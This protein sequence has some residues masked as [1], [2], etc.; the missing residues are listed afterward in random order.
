MAAHLVDGRPKDWMLGMINSSAGVSAFLPWYLGKA[1]A[2]SL[3]R[4]LLG[5][6]LATYVATPSILA[7]LQSV[8]D[9][10]WSTGEGCNSVLAAV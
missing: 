10:S 5:P 6:N 9:G 4:T 8:H 1:A 7:R 2:S 3:A